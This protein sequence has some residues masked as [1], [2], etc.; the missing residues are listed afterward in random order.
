[1]RKAD[2]RAALRLI[3]TELAGDSFTRVMA[4]YAL[5]WT[6]STAFHRLSVSQQDVIRRLLYTY[7]LENFKTS[8]STRSNLRLPPAPKNYFPY[9]RCRID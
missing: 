1:M 9:P 8:T 4:G 2:M 6:Y 3:Y 7:G 5:K